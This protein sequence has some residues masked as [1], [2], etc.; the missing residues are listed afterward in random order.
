LTRSLTS[1][2]E[3]FSSDWLGVA[4]S[5]VAKRIEARFAQFKQ[6]KEHEDEQR[7][8]EQQ[9]LEIGNHDQSE[10]SKVKE[11]IEQLKTP[12]K[13]R[14]LPEIPKVARSQPKSIEVH[15]EVEEASESQQKGTVVLRLR[16]AARSAS[17]MG[18]LEPRVSDVPV[19]NLDFLGG[20]LELDPTLLTYSS[21]PG[22][23]FDFPI[24]LK[25]PAGNLL[26]VGDYRFR[27]EVTVPVKPDTKA[28]VNTAEPT[29]APDGAPA[30]GSPT[31]EA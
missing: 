18:K 14:P 15:Q 10:I 13:N 9:L 7:L 31:G 26:P 11:E 27:Y 16:R 4:S 30:A 1:S 20:P 24:N 2:N 21:K 6:K 22:T 17:G 25:Y 19:A 5:K 12:S 28:A 8:L 29:P 3:V 23:K